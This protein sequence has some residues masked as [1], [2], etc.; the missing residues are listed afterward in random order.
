MRIVV[1]AENVDLS[2]EEIDK[3]VAVASEKERE[4]DF[5]VIEGQGA[6]PSLPSP[7]YGTEEPVD[8]GGYPYVNEFLKSRGFG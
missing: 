4:K 5:T 6:P 2:D 3:A 1:Y 8:D 7:L